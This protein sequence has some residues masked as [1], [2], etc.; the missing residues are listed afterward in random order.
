MYAPKQNLKNKRAI[1][2]MAIKDCAEYAKTLQ[3]C[4]KEI[5]IINVRE[6][7]IPCANLLGAGAG[8]NFGSFLLL[9]IVAL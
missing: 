3:F 9:A 2:A 7:A 5:P 6:A 1:N 4:I 8:F